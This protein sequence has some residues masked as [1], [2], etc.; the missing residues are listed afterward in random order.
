MQDAT[1]VAVR[2]GAAGEGGFEMTPKDGRD[3]S[4]GEQLPTEDR[5]QFRAS[6]CIDLSIDADDAAYLASLAA[7]LTEWVS[8]EDCAAYDKL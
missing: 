8:A 2:Y 5:V 3:K 4:P 1:K 6:P 7:L